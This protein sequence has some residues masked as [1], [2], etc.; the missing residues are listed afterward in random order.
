MCVVRIFRHSILVKVHCRQLC[1]SA[2]VME[3]KECDNLGDR[4][5]KRCVLLGRAMKKFERRS[6]NVFVPRHMGKVHR[7]DGVGTGKVRFKA[8]QTMMDDMMRA[9][10]KDWTLSETQKSYHRVF[11]HALIPHIF[12]VSVFERSQHEILAY[13]G[14][15]EID[16]AVLV[17]AAR[18]AG[19]TIA[20]AVLIAAFLLCV[21]GHRGLIIS[22]NQYAS[23]TLM[24]QVRS[25]I[26]AVGEDRRM[27]QYN[28][29]SMRV[30][31]VPLAAGRGLKSE[32][33]HTAAML[34]TTSGVVSLPSTVDSK[35]PCPQFCLHRVTLDC[36]HVCVLSLRAL[37]YS[38]TPR[39]NTESPPHRHTQRTGV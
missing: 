5:I 16:M 10:N 17:R 21:P 33:A 26:L 11:M 4:W 35:T 18:R 32:A 14:I 15:E 12:G 39:H 25:F 20:V 2:T 28:N 23:T 30:A 29:K 27:V 38:T 13:Y 34:S 3:M 36:T 9:T 8:M 24:A 22:Q 37:I 19:K 31:V 6:E 1:V 7:P